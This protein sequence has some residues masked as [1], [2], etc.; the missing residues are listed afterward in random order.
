MDNSSQNISSIFAVCSF[1]EILHNNGGT[2]HGLYD[3]CSERG[4][5]IW[6]KSGISI[7]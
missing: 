7:C 3:G 1:S 4:A 6:R 5:L 2:Q